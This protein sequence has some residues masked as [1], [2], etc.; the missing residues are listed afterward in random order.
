MKLQHYG[1]AV[2]VAFAVL[3]AIGSGSQAQN[4]LANPGFEALGGSYDGWFTF[5]AGVQLSTPD[6]DNIIRTDSTAA[7]IY[8]EFT[9]CDIPIPTFDV[10]GFGQAFLSPVAGQLYRFSGWTFV[11][12]GDPIPGTN[13]CVSNRLL[14]KIVFFNATAGGA[15]LASNE[16]I[17]GDGNS[18]LDT[19]NEFSIEAP[20]PA[21]ALRVEALFL[22][23]Q[24][25][26]DTGSV[27]VD[28]V[29][30][31]EITPDTP[32]TNLLANPSFDSTL[33]GWNV[34]GNVYPDGRSWALRSRPY[35]AKLFGPF[36]GP[37]D[38][39]G[40]FQTFPVT[41]GTELEMSIHA[42]TT[43]V[44]SP[45]NAAGNDNYL[46][47][48][49][50]YFDNAY[51]VLDTIET[52]VIDS[53]TAMGTWFRHSISLTAPAGV[54][55]V[56]AY[57]LFIQ[58]SAEGGAVWVDDLSLHEVTTTGVDDIPTA[59]ILYQNVPNPFN[60]TTRIDF[61][62]ATA[63]K[64]DINVYDVTGRHIATLLDEYRDAGIHRVMWDGRNDKGGIVASGVYYYSLVTKDESITR[65]MVLLR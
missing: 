30:F 7:K 54:D 65:K 29:S 58:P 45:M 23:L 18:I 21:G 22:F 43:C 52:V 27:F 47:I 60:P 36:A 32:P 4:L 64:V 63:G 33:D 34:F 15:E 12:S 11:S 48:K 51:T 59:S 3:L 50:V 57:V 28:D 14:A 25:G 62:L 38:A 24:P 8:G 10:G 61:N 42:L 56:S 2:L 39:S 40:L 49:L 53:T 26:C 17:V 13:P 6:G 46:S 20:C 1:K 44:E 5:G 41:E 55:S 31:E 9:N 35:G 37:G 19:W 16:I